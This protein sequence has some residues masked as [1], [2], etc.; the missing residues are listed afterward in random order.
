MSDSSCRY[1]IAWEQ[2]Y[3]VFITSSA[4]RQCMLQHTNTAALP[5]VWYCLT[6]A[7]AREPCIK[8]CP[9][10]QLL[11]EWNYSVYH[12]TH[13]LW[14]IDIQTC[15]FAGLLLQ[16][17]RL[18][19]ISFI[20][21]IPLIKTKATVLLFCFVFCYFAH[22]HRNTQFSILLQL[23][24][25]FYSTFLKY[26]LRMLWFI[27]MWKCDIVTTLT[28]VKGKRGEIRTRCYSVDLHS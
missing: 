10:C 21:L 7:K 15:G 24:K 6:N 14:F 12:L 11:W 28:E 5:L 27:K 19:R 3:L 13:C 2:C 18:T 26:I 22:S 25:K 17:S 1:Y 20:F 16:S 4:S 23:L 8:L 9:C